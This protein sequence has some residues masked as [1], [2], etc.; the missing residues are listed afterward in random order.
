M[1]LDVSCGNAP[2]GDVNVDLPCSERHCDRIKILQR[3][4]NGI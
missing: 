4:S 1:K 3:K 2:T